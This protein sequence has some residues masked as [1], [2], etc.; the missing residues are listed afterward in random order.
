MCWNYRGYGKSEKGSWFFD[1]INP[2]ICKA[3]SE[4]VLDF[5][6]NKLK[7]RGKIALYGRSLGGIASCHLANKYPEQIYALLVDRTFGELE[8][9]SEKRLLGCCTKRIYNMVSCRW[10]T[11]NAYNFA[12]AKCYKI[13]TCDPK[14]DVVDN[15]ASLP[16][17]ASHYLIK[18]NYKDTTTDGT[19]RWHNFYEA[20]KFLYDLEDFLYQK[21]SDKNEEILKYR[22]LKSI[23]DNDIEVNKVSLFPAIE[24]LRDYKKQLEIN[25]SNSSR[26]MSLNINKTQNNNKFSSFNNTNNN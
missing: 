2:Y 6:L 11:G 5:M 10:R 12:R 14:D 17:L 9:V 22:F 26:Q 13:I 19:D 16:V 8:A 1:T 15:F 3:D 7:L 4:R 23:E 21:L 24:Q 20:L 18:N 25:H